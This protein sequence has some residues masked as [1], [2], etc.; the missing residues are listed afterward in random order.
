MAAGL[1]MP[2]IP[3]FVVF[4]LHS[5]VEYV[6]IITSISS[7]ASVPALIFW[8]NLSDKIKKRKIFILIGFFGSFFSLI[9]IFLIHSIPEYLLMLILFQIITMAGVPVS[10]L[11]ILEDS[12]KSMWPNVMGKFNSFSAGGTVIGLGAGVIILVLFASKGKIILPYLYFISSFIYLTAGI[13][14]FI[15]LKEPAKN[16]GR[17]KLGFIFTLH[18]IE[19]IRYFPTHI[20]HIPGEA[21]RIKIPG[22]LKKYLITTLILMMGFQLFLIPYPVFVIKRI[23]ANEN[24]IYIMYLLN[25]LFS[26]LTFIPAGKYLN[27]MGS[28]KMLLYSTSLRIILFLF[29]GIISFFVY[30]TVNFLVLFI[31]IYGILGAV[32]SFIGISEITSISNM[33]ESTVRGKIIGYYN[34]LS[35]IGQIIGAGLSGF[36]AFDIGYSVDFMISAIIVLSGLLIIVKTKPPDITPVKK[37]ITS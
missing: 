29:T 5:N 37:V 15:I 26:A 25:S 20:L 21:S 22:Y 28:N 35:G 4:Y 9:I 10:T 6:G 32:W 8:G 19:R 27:L 34:S 13:F 11:L 24:D 1:T 23:N 18:V 7:L 2:L 16:I 36:I 12:E 17:K 31:L 3:L 30:D 33:C 14:S